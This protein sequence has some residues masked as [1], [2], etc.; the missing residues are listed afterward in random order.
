MDETNQKSAWSRNRLLLRYE[1]TNLSPGDGMYG[2]VCVNATWGLVVATRLSTL[3]RR[4]PHE[5]KMS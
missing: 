3:G 1:Q 2:V 5:E 4:D